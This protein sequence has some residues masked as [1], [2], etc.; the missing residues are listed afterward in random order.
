MELRQLRQLAV[1]AETLNFHRAAEALHMS[2]PPLSVSI[3]KLE[4][5]LGVPLFGRE[6]R[7]V[8][9]TAAGEAALSHAHDALSS[10]MAMV[11][12]VHA[13]ADGR[14]GRLRIGF[15][16]S[17]TYA[18]IPAVV[19]VFRARSP[20]IKLSLK[21]TTTLEIIRALETGTL[22][23]GIVRTPV[24]DVGD[25]VL[26]PLA[27][28]ELILVTPPDHWLG[29]GRPEVRLEELKDEAFV[30][31]DRERVPNLWSFTISSC[32]AAG[33]MP[34]IAEEATHLHTLIALVQ[35][36]VGIGMTPAVIR[37]A[38]SDRVRYVR[39]T[40]RGAP[41]K[42]GLAVATR[43]RERRP[44]VVGFSSALREVACLLD[45]D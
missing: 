29:D 33:F 34:K 27:Q 22:D 40:S 17:A 15:V 21:E 30:V 39:L 13:T 38:G 9:L 26:E 6:G 36:G 32:V 3:R 10:V 20:G 11:E 16:A 37:R 1:L 35:S 41:L 5:E 31:Y 2:Q 28:E 8:T 19:P 43:R 42:I 12:A 14:Q 44:T 4:R 23:V 18:L 25:V 24:F 7:R 45:S